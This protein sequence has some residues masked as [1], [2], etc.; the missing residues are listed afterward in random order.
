MLPSRDSV[1]GAVFRRAV[2]IVFHR[3]TIIPQNAVHGTERGTVLDLSGHLEAWVAP[4][5][6]NEVQKATKLMRHHF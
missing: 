2:A 5:C 3:I 1:T 6:I 4:R